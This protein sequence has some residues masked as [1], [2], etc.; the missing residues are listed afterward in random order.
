[1]FRLG[2]PVVRAT[3]AGGWGCDVYCER[4]MWYCP[5]LQG[6]VVRIIMRRLMR[7]GQKSEPCQNLPSGCTTHRYHDIPENFPKR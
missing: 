4:R 2:G 1:M 6:R 7:L 5:L 3:V